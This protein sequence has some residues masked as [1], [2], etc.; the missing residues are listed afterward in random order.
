MTFADNATA[1]VAVLG[2]VL[3]AATFLAGFIIS[4]TFA[5]TVSQR[6]RDLALLRLV[7][8]SRGQVRRLL[9]G[10]AVLLG[11]LGAALGIPAGLGVMAIQSRL[12]GTLGFVPDGFTGRVAAVDPRR[13]RRHRR[14][15]RGRRGAGRRPPR[16]S[17]PPAGGVAGHRASPH[18]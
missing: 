1:A 17:G 12:L 15:A 8:G 14:R 7:G 13:L 10:E 2:V 9:L 18:A 16:R 5:F 3:G 6:R 11:G 4:S